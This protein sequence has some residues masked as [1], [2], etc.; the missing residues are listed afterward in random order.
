[1]SLQADD[2]NSLVQLEL[3]KARRTFSEVAKLKDLGYWETLANR[4]YY[5]VF[6]AVSALLVSD[7]H[8]VGTH[9]GSI[10]VFSLHYVKTGKF[11]PEEGR[12]YSQLETMRERGD[13]DIIFHVTPEEVAPRIIP[14]GEMIDHIEQ[15]IVQRHGR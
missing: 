7:G 6:H 15:Y 2:R 1:M 3:E 13:Y 9:H 11:S 12:L 10:A 4:L 8:K 14:A 5:A